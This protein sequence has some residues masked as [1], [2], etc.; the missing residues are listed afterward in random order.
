M[1][2]VGDIVNRGADSLSALRWAYQNQ[3]RVQLVLGNHDLHMLACWAG[4]TGLR[5]E[6]RL[7]SVLQAPD[8]EQ[9]MTWLRGRPLVV[10]DGKRL[11][12]HAG[13]HPHWDL[14]SILEYG[15]EVAEE[16][17]GKRFT[18]FLGQLYRQKLVNWTWKEDET[19]RLER[20]CA[21]AAIFSRVRMVKPDG[22]CVLA[23]TGAPDSAPRD[24]QP[25]FENAKVI[26]EG[27]HVYFGHWAQMG[28][29]SVRGATCID[30]ACVYGG[31][32]TAL[33]LE[34]GTLVSVQKNG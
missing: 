30:S 29:T 19:D 32:L 21:A 8:G 2:L 18:E 13:V 10:Q 15:A 31:S 5:S 17:G 11:L 25:W 7:D 23:F 3:D 28:M 33:D 26:K 20:A 6:D 22:G 12:V 16:L 34:D 14:E 9:L 27:M 4:V 1:W 24:L